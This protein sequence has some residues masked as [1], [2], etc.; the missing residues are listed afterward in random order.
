MP[1]DEDAYAIAHDSIEEVIRKPPEVHPPQVAFEE[2]VS[3]WPQRS[4]QRLVSHGSGL[5][6]VASE[7]RPMQLRWGLHFRI[8]SELT[9]QRLNEL[10]HPRWQIDAL[11]HSDFTKS[12]TVFAIEP[13]LKPVS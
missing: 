2:M 6:A 8:I 3:A 4:L 7:R 1:D 11:T 13:A 12:L 10:T 9:S 5:S